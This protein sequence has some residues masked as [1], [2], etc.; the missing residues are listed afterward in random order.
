[1]HGDDHLGARGV[2]LMYSQSFRRRPEPSDFRCASPLPYIHSEFPRP[3]LPCM[4]SPRTSLDRIGTP[5]AFA[6]TT[7]VY[8]QE[9]YQR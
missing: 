2:A 5:S 7:M 4:G 6:G 8:G 3:F 9:V 1:M